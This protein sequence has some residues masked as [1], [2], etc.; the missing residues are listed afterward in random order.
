MVW[1][2]YRNR[3]RLHKRAPFIQPLEGM[4]GNLELLWRFITTLR[5]SK[6]IKDWLKNCVHAAANS[7]FPQLCSP[8]ML[9]SSLAIALSIGL[10]CK[11]SRHSLL[12]S[13]S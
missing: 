8:I 10:Q 9:S 12:V 7:R 5:F 13:R 4:A 6:E 2:N 1:G 3:R 11:L